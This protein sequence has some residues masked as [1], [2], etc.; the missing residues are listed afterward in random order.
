MATPT[1]NDRMLKALA[2]AYVEKPRA[3]LKQLA[4]AA[5]T[6]TATLHRLCGTR[7]A[8]V[9]MLESQGLSA[10]NQVIADAELTKA[11]PLEALRRMIVGHLAQRE[12]L[13][14]MMFQ[15]RPDSNDPGNE[16]SRWASYTDALDTFFL[17]GQHEGLFRIDISAQMLTELFSAMLY[18]VVDAERCGRAASATSAIVFEKF[19]LHGGSA[20]KV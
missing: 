3:T 2:A 8:L 17:R 14:F 18:G 1:P 16:C 5:G 13:L 7:E 19:F 6:S 12:L 4:D 15:Y 11:E 20:Q 10:L 9:K